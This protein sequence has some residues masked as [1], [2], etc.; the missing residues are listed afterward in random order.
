M[1]FCTKC[2]AAVEDYVRFCASCGAPVE[3]GA[4]QNNTA[5]TAYNKFTNKGNTTSAYSPDDIRKNKVVAVLCYL[6]TLYL[7]HNYA[8]K[9]SPYAKFHANQGLVLCI[10]EFGYNV[11]IIIIYIIVDFSV[12][13]M[14][15]FL[16]DILFSVLLIMGIVNAATGKAKKLPL[17]GRIT[18]YK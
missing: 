2:G 9:D 3:P 5:Q 6:F 12:V 16:V 18:L 15:L 17:I 13:W 1:P 8:V 14:S 11:A 10:F 4:A 7:I